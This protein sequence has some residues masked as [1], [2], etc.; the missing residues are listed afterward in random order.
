[1]SQRHDRR[2]G[3]YQSTAP[4]AI[5]RKGNKVPLTNPIFLN[6]KSKA[7]CFILIHR[8]SKTLRGGPLRF[9]VSVDGV[10]IGKPL[11]NGNH[12]LI[13][14]A[15]GTHVVLAHMPHSVKNMDRRLETVDLKPGDM[16]FIELAIVGLTIPHTKVWDHGRRD[17][18]IATVRTR[19]VTKPEETTTTTTTTYT[20]QQPQQIVMP[21]PVYYTPHTQQPMGTAPM[22]FSG[23]TPYPPPQFMPAPMYYQPPPQQL[24]Q[25]QL[26]QQQQPRQPPVG[27]FVVPSSTMPPS[28]PV[29]SQ[30]P[31]Q[32]FYPAYHPPQYPL[33]QPPPQQLQ[34]L[35]QLQ[36]QQQQQQQQPLGSIPA[37]MS[38]TYGSPPPTNPFFHPSPTPPHH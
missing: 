36:Q 18:P 5:G 38:Q 30:P 7:P 23:P 22:P 9:W 20:V 2:H 17:C 10:K 21:A 6:G 15:P 24:Q 27:M 33:S 8:R 1:M 25:Q 3:N 28:G 13:G 35:H 34:Q 19:K 32:P 12:L 29:Y 11:E 14:V 16:H 4:H 26:Q 31:Q 37:P